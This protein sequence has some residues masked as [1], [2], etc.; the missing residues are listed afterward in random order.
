MNGNHVL[1][2]IDSVAGRTS[3][4]CGVSATKDLCPRVS[5]HKDPAI[6]LES[7]TVSRRRFHNLT[8]CL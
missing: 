8:I 1:H 6:E 3:F 7:G 5:F 2:Y 4:F